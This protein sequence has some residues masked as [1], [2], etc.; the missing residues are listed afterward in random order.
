MTQ[1]TWTIGTNPTANG[2]YNADFASAKNPDLYRWW[3]GKNWSVG[4]LK[5]ADKY[6]PNVECPKPIGAGFNKDIAW[7]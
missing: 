4:V 2:W 1:A 5:S 6:H 7:R 3:N